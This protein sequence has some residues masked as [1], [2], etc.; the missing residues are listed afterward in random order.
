M[1]DNNQQLPPQSEITSK[2]R[3]TAES[4]I[5]AQKD[6]ELVME[7]SSRTGTTQR[8]KEPPDPL[9]TSTR[10]GSAPV[11]PTNTRVEGRRQSLTPG[12]YNYQSFDW[13]QSTEPPVD[14][15]DPLK[16]L[17]ASLHRL[18]LDLA[19]FE[20]TFD[21]DPNWP[22]KLWTTELN[23]QT[24][25]D[26][27]KE[28]ADKLGAHDI[29]FKCEGLENRLRNA[30]KKWNTKLDE[31]ADSDPSSPFH[32]Y[33]T[34]TNPP[35]N[36]SEIPSL[37]LLNTNQLNLIDDVN[38]LQ[39]QEAILPLITQTNT[40]FG[41][42][43]TQSTPLMNTDVPLRNNVIEEDHDIT[44]HHP[45][46]ERNT[47][48]RRSLAD[49]I[50]DAN[51]PEAGEDEAI[52][53]NGGSENLDLTVYDRS[54]GE[55]PTITY[56]MR[57]IRANK[58]DV[59]EALNSNE[60]M[61]IKKWGQIED[62][63]LDVSQV[64]ASITAI[65]QGILDNTE[66]D[67][68]KNKEAQDNLRKDLVDLDAY[69]KENTWGG[70]LKRKTDNTA[71][72]AMKNKHSIV[73]QGL[74]IDRCTTLQRH[75]DL[76][77][78][79][80]QL[81]ATVDN[82]SQR[83][84]DVESQNSILTVKLAK[85][86]R[87]NQQVTTL[88]VF[89][90]CNSIMTTT[91]TSAM[92]MGPAVTTPA[93]TPYFMA[94]SSV[95]RQLNQHS[96]PQ[97]QLISPLQ[98]FAQPPAPRADGPANVENTET[99]QSP[100][101]GS[102]NVEGLTSMQGPGFLPRTLRPEADLNND[103]INI[104]LLQVPETSS[105][106]IGQQTPYTS[107]YQSPF[108][109]PYR[110]QGN[111]GPSALA[112]HETVALLV[113]QLEELICKDI[114]GSAP[115]EKIKEYRTSVTQQVSEVSKRCNDYIIQ[116]AACAGANP[117]LTSRAFSA[118]RESSKWMAR[119]RNLAES[120]ESYSRPLGKEFL[121][122]LPQF[123]N[124]SVMNI[125]EFFQRFEQKFQGKGT[126]KDRADILVKKYLAPKITLQVTEFLG[127]YKKIKSFLY[128]KY[129]DIHTM[130]DTIL[131]DLEARK[132]L[133]QGATPKAT[134][135][136]FTGLLSDIFKIKNLSKI[137]EITVEQFNSHI[138]SR[139][140]LA[141]IANVLP[142]H[143]RIEFNMRAQDKNIDPDRLQGQAA[144]ECIVEYSNRI[145][146]GLGSFADD[147]L[148]RNTSKGNRRSPQRTTNMA[149]SQSKSSISSS[150]SEE[151]DDGGSAGIHAVKKSPAKNTD[152]STKKWYKDGL[153]SPCP[154]EN[155]THEIG[156][157]N[158][159]FSLTSKERHETSS[160]KLCYTCLGPW[161]T[162]RRK[163]SRVKQIPQGL[164]CAECT[165][166]YAGTRRTP[167]NVLICSKGDHSKPAPA[168]LIPH[169]KNWF[170]NFNPKITLELRANLLIASFKPACH[171]CLE[172]S[173]CACNI[174][175]KSSQVDPDAPIPVIDTQTGKDI[176]DSI[177]DGDVIK[178]VPESSIFVMQSLNIRGKEFL[179]FY[180]RGASQHLINGRMAEEVGIKVL[181]DRP[182][183]LSVVGGGSI[184]TE[185][186][187]YRMALGKTEE[188]KVHDLICQGMTSIT[189][190]FPKYDL[191]K[192]NKELRECGNKALQPKEKLPLEVGG[193]EVHLLIGI[194]DTALEPKLLFTL[195]SGIGV[196][197]SK[198]KDKFGS[199]ICY[200]GPHK[201]FTEIH[202][203]S[204]GKTHFMA[205]MASFT[206]SYTNSLLNYIPINDEDRINQKFEDNGHQVLIHKEHAINYSLD[207]DSEMQCKIFPTPLTEAD[208]TDSL[209]TPPQDHFNNFDDSSPP[210]ISKEDD[211][212]YERFHLCPV[213]KAKIPLSRLRELMDKE[214]TEDTVTYRCEKCLKCIKC[215]SSSKN[216]A[217][218]LKESIE[219]SFID[220]SVALE[221]GLLWVDIPFIKDPVPFMTK[222]HKGPNNKAQALHVYKSQCKKSP[223][224]KEAMR[225]VHKDLVAK[226]F[227]KKLSDLTDDQQK[228]I[229]KALF[230]HFYPWSIVINEGSLSTRARLVVDPTM[231]G[232]NLII[233]K[234]ENRL[235][236]IAEILLRS[237][238][239]RFIWT[240]DISKLYNQ[241][242]LRDGSLPFSL[243]YYHE[244]LDPSV[245]P[246][247]WVMTT[248][249]YGVASSA[250]QSETSLSLVA[251]AGKEQFPKSIEPLEEGRYVDDMNSGTNSE[252][253]REEQIEHTREALNLGGLKMKF[254]VKS[255]SEPPPEASTDGVSLKMLGYRYEPV[256]DT[257]AL[258]FSE[259]NF[260]RKVRGAKKPNMEPVLNKLEAL[261]LM[262]TLIVTRQIVAS[263]LA[264]LFDPLGLWEPYKVQLKLDMSELNGMDWKKP[265]PQELQDH[266][267][268][269]FLQ[270][271]ELN[272][273]H[274]TRCVI[275]AEVNAKTK[276][277]LLCISDAAI[278][279]G[280]AAVYAN[281]K[282]NDGRYSCTL[283]TS[284]SRL[285]DGTVPRN[286]L[287]AIMLM[288]ELAFSV[289]RAITDAIEEILYVTDSMIAMCWVF[290]TNKKLRL[291][292]LN[293]VSLIRQ[294]IEWTTGETTTLP[295]F[296]IEGSLNPADLLTKKHAIEPSDLAVDSPWQKGMEWMNLP[297]SQMPLKSYEGIRTDAK[298]Q[299]EV[300]KECFQ[301][302]F[303]PKTAN[304]HGMF[305]Q[306]LEPNSV[307]HCEGC[308]TD[309]NKPTIH[310]QVYTCYGRAND[311][312]HCDNCD[313]NLIFSSYSKGGRGV[314][315]FP[316][317]IIHHGWK[318]SINIM[319]RITKTIATWTH[320]THLGTKNIKVKHSLEERCQVCETSNLSLDQICRREAENHLYRAEAKIIVPRMS[321]KKLEE[322]TQENGILWSTGRIAE[323]N[324]IK[325]RDLD[326]D[327]F[328][329]NVEI[330]T[331]LPVVSA[332]S[333]V[334]YAFVVH[335]HTKIRP[336]S[337]VEI[338]MREVFK[339]MHV[340]DN[341]RRVIQR[342][343]QDCARCRLILK[344]TMD[345]EMAQH[346]Q[347]RTTLA[348][349]F[350]NA[351]ADIAYGFKGKPYLGARK[352]CQIYAMVIVC[353]LTSA[354]S[355]LALEG[356]QTQNV[357]QTLERHS[358]RY[359]VPN[360]LFVDNG[361]QLI[362]LQNNEFSIRDV[363]TFMYDSVGMQ[364][365]V[366]SAKSHESRGRVEAKVKILRSM[367][368]K[369]AINTTTPM[370]ALQWETCFSRISNQLDDLPMA[371]GN[372]SNVSDIGWDII[373]PNRLKLGRNNSR[374]LSGPISL[375]GGSG[376]DNLLAVNRAAQ[377]TWYQL[378]LDRIHHLILKPKKW[379]KTDVPSVGDI[380]LFVYLDGLKAK[381]GAQW[382]LGKVITVH[383]GSRKVTIAFPEKSQP[384]SLK[385]PKLKTLIRCLREVSVI[386]AVGDFSIN[387]KEHFKACNKN[388]NEKN[389]AAKH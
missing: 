113:E 42:A 223:A 177:Q 86:T 317:D 8:H 131:A 213:L 66:T 168:D 147:A 103:L 377:V 6:T 312:D 7:P 293:R 13:D 55:I 375:T 59:Y 71:E 243:F 91:T 34:L 267:K 337:G 159:F 12:D 305:T 14:D 350:Y 85:A 276:V 9:L 33:S 204:R 110:T 257:Y 363:D 56:I 161:Q 300:D 48:Y 342:I 296:H 217:I 304:V 128:E 64:Q 221:D 197:R 376:W 298:V 18:A 351:M 193:T 275:P 246:E 370:T 297:T 348:P 83:L 69:V 170:P 216:K 239:K 196:Y 22:G 107:P 229:N 102:R 105:A 324:S 355:I 150:S 383:S 121:E 31:M 37:P 132:R 52:S 172:D 310:V 311:H 140:F 72:I 366:S 187:L 202:K 381:S 182:S 330:K 38:T 108:S 5:I 269:R 367:L 299:Q 274:V 165:A 232:L 327:A 145:L 352:D 73:N 325:E 343:R 124:H 303:L 198:L 156:T 194:K 49:E 114:D 287:S 353:I 190:D 372:S 373:T 63:L 212:N 25:I 247:I 302:V 146:V 364:V 238:C 195:D 254:V 144:M 99:Q 90:R 326:L 358:S 120:K 306:K 224:A 119:I 266:W 116:Y 87:Q 242:R 245:H 250:G 118:V 77:N 200:G 143:H 371:K 280:G 335:I 166:I 290:N 23:L 380:V 192:I 210:M 316:I 106:G 135:E 117:I 43:Q 134:S 79:V 333:P 265:L 47:D 318:H 382:K 181:T 17:K 175:T 50:N 160:R 354:T 289:K 35:L 112:L 228:L 97:V 241:M 386:H 282:I 2:T 235:G 323:I 319:T 30:S 329:D 149:R 356:L 233:A 240:T 21:K 92:P 82:L 98:N 80:K 155:H 387:T 57:D 67:R 251:E 227:M 123:S 301:D 315:G 163:C 19:S 258:S 339:T 109:S 11:S 171:K 226:G 186:G 255:G 249:W 268:W 207:T 340:I 32:G 74:R 248:A 137:H 39:L 133:V 231:S 346:D 292:T 130:T 220:K 314:E 126:E 360:K 60:K 222:R 362:A 244:A 148:R 4:E 178:E 385:I 151:E 115:T 273:L 344:K 76:S 307:Q 40:E 322:Y 62:K 138:H 158:K 162:C 256:K 28:E 208:F 81:Q 368:A 153:K 369:L 174:P 272:Q 44:R 288:T 338:T 46:I 261:E 185:Y 379:L 154:I 285:M 45:G 294:M 68:R 279:A 41:S 29:V 157:C 253:E 263:K 139:A 283:L 341:P 347:A 111:Q 152:T 219:Q 201:I 95:E 127:N 184:S 183:S 188:G 20:F 215:K 191:T 345:L 291:Y 332:D 328:F 173:V 89:N 164:L 277:R 389:N 84:T 384:G 259:L 179:T 180:D 167:Y 51:H 36:A 320:Q 58:P 271:M 334:F 313:C 361:T 189:T 357:I 65:H 15:H 284:K 93:P 94:G 278:H 349:P 100:D 169:L 230:L 10:I 211:Q 54:R 331:I 141:R 218:S 176:H 237:R 199:T 24:R 142:E 125:Y 225:Q 53:E 101:A 75:V 262:S 3:R 16:P 308:Q 388:G 104:P 260:N 281:Y 295:L 1:A 96:I 286:E 252:E 129:G 70:E 27:A 359:G 236:K 234:G 336:H 214:D 378:F 88:P 309:L 206:K 122:E 321:K 136:F 365:E 78:T 61:A 209:C 270:F 205:F 374:S 264:E 203:Q 26:E